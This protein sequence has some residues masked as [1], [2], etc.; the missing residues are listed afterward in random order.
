[1]LVVKS[2]IRS[3]VE[4]VMYRMKEAGSKE[5]MLSE[6]L[7]PPHPINCCTYLVAWTAFV[8]FSEFAST[9]FNFRSKKSLVSLGFFST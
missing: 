3:F 1:M 6:M 4:R 5:G 9:I 2:E 8:I 7:F